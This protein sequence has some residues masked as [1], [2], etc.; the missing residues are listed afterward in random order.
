MASVTSA[1]SVQPVRRPAVGPGLIGL[2]AIGLFINYVDRGNLATA[3]P[4]IKDELGLNNTEAGILLSAF[5]WTYMPFQLAAGWLAERFSPY[6][7]LAIG[8]A[9]W[10]FATFASGFVT[11]FT[12]LLLLRLVLGVGESATFPCN[13]KILAR[14]LAPGKLGTANGLIGMGIPLGP[15]IGTFGGGLLIAWM[16]WRGLFIVFGALSAMWLIP[17][18]LA[19]RRM[20]APPVDAP[21]G[22]APGFLAILARRECLGVSLG[23][24]AHNYSLYFVI[25]WLPLYLV[26]SRGFSVIEMGEL[27][28]ILYVVNAI[29]VQ[30]SGIFA[31]RLIAA[32]R[33]GT[34]VRKGFGVIG[35][36]GIATCML[37]GMAGAPVA[38]IVALL[39]SGWFFGMSSS[40]IFP[41]GQTLAGP[42]AAGKWMGVQN[43][44][45][46]LAG[47]IA[48][49]V[50]GYV[51]DR[52]GNFAI[53]F[54]VAAGVTT[55]GVVG[56]LIIA[57]IE[58][59]DWTEKAT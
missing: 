52:T 14:D 59:L 25:S 19:V 8:V 49:I 46:N 3:A 34:A 5:F 40:T 18:L 4:L 24:F 28:G 17:W 33:S 55:V 6:R 32:G 39:A 23:H 57:R 11:G 1:L 9:L 54:A 15:A 30:A 56:W 7:I 45:G 53:A 27:G 13:A 2:L 51:V 12:S 20:P 48:P 26:K 31:D 44:L 38:S 10:S 58:T 21:V 43:C 29:S 42:H 35:L 47:I 50:T 22:A 36:L 41:T 16:G 37:G